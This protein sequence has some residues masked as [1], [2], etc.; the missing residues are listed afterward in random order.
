MCTGS[1]VRPLKSQSLNLAIGNTLK[2][3]LVR[4]NYAQHFVNKDIFTFYYSA[5]RL[6]A[7]QESLRQD[8]LVRDLEEMK[9]CKVKNFVGNTMG[10]WG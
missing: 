9:T 1:S 5:K 7:F 10:R 6:L 4:N 3:P 2:E 8:V